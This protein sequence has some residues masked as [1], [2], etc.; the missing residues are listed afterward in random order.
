MVS[1]QCIQG[2]Q[3]ELIQNFGDWDV[4]LNDNEH[5]QN[6]ILYSLDEKYLVVINGYGS[7]KTMVFNRSS[8]TLLYSFDIYSFDNNTI[9][10]I[11]EIIAATIF[12]NMLILYDYLYQ[13]LFVLHFNGTVIK[14]FYWPA[15]YGT[16]QSSNFDVASPVYINSLNDEYLYICSNSNITKETQLNIT[17]FNYN[18]IK[19]SSVSLVSL[20]PR[21]SQLAYSFLLNVQ[22]LNNETLFMYIYSNP[23]LSCMLSYDSNTDYWTVNVYEIK[24]HPLYPLFYSNYL[25]LFYYSSTNRVFFVTNSGNI[26]GFISSLPNGRSLSDSIAARSYNDIVYIS[27]S[28]HQVLLVIKLN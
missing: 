19:V 17:V 26:I 25:N 13:T 5:L 1:P 2:F 6:P 18:L 7:N 12:N 16:E 22:N 11:G 9:L 28:I 24:I 15:T 4:A 21:L 10:R 14:N 8:L 3:Y 20:I 27:D 23:S